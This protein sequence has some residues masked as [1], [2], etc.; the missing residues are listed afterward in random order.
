MFLHKTQL[1][2]IIISFGLFLSACKEEIVKPLPGGGS[3]IPVPVTNVKVENR[4]GEAKIIYTVPADPN[5][6]Y[7]EANWTQKGVGRNAKASYYS[8]TLLLQGFGDTSEYEVKVYS[9]NK[10]EQ[11]SAPVV[12]KVKPL[13]SPVE[14]V[15]KSIVD[16][17]VKAD[18]GGLNVGF[19]N[20]TGGNVV[21]NVI[22]ANDK[23]DMAQADAFYTNQLKG[24]FSTRGFDTLSRV[25]G[26]FVKDRWGN[27]SD[28]LYATIKPL[29]ELQLNKSLFR[30]VNP[31]PGDVNDK[32]YSAAYPMNKLWDNN[33]GTIYVTANA[34]G[35]PE[36][37]TIDLGV[38]AK[39]SRMKYFQRQSTAFYYTSQTPMV[40][41]VY[42][43]NSPA[44]DGNWN[45]WTLLTNCVSTKP[46]GLPLGITTSE[47]VSAAVAGENFNFPATGQGYRYLRFKVLQTYGN[48][49]SITFSELTFWGA[50]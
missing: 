4:H 12:V 13:T 30:E 35:M 3:G 25:F 21:I 8:D 44:P 5:L 43:S 22:T 7:V 39:L 26:V 29:F 32:I 27:F 15:Y 17:G 10:S 48:A 19:I 49:T 23:G 50:Y 2:F 36:S 40:F 1:Y 18:F 47:D 45:S 42:G 34:L 41:D 31:Y 16:L 9:V 11:R 24:N 14:E 28:T 6:L 33:T 38:T 20:A 37:F 46:S